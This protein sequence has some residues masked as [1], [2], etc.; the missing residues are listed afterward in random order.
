MHKAVNTYF[1]TQMT[2]TTQGDVLLSLYDAA[3][4]FLTEAKERIDAKDPGGKGNLISKALDI[5]AELDSTLNIEKG[6]DLAQ[7]LHQLYF[8]CSKHLLMANLKMS[9][10]MIDEVIKILAG[11]RDAYS[12][13]ANQPEAQA[14]GREAAEMVLATSMQTRAQPSTAST[15]TVHSAN[16]PGVALRQRNSYAQAMGQGQPEASTTPAPEGSQNSPLAPQPEQ[17]A[18]NAAPK[19]MALKGYK[20]STT[21]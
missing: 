5:I 14:A 6:K 7:N 1:Q 15:G 19:G 17:E 2:T 4:R 11:L 3:I 18:G 21:F 9:K 10:P 20:L 13:I 12:Q 8:F 16:T